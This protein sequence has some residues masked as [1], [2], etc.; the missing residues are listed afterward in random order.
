MPKFSEK[1]RIPLLSILV[2]PNSITVFHGITPALAK[3][4]SPKPFIQDFFHGAPA[5]FPLGCDSQLVEL[6]Q[7]GAFNNRNAH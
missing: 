2:I 3:R 5:T 7:G 1:I 6:P 4:T